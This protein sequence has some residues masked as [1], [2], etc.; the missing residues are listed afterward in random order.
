M[1]WITLDRLEK[2]WERAEIHAR[3]EGEVIRVT[4]TNIAAF[5]ITLSEKPRNVVINDEEVARDLDTSAAGFCKLGG[6][7][8]RNPPDF[9]RGLHKTHGLTG[10]I[11][12]AFM[13]SFILVRPTGEA[14]NERV[15]AWA[16]GELQR[17]VE[18]WRRVFR[19]DARVKNDSEITAEDIARHNLVL[20][21]D[22]GS[23]QLLAR[24]LPSLPL[25]W[26]RAQLR[27]G[28]V[29]ASPSDHA[30]IMIYPNPLN[31]RRYVVINSG[32]TYREYDY[33]NN[34]RQVPRLPDFAVIDVSK[35]V[36]SQYPGGVAAAG[37]FDEKWQLPAK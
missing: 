17:A 1:K 21:G 8:Q 12:D 19:G 10:P 25:E 37:F 9:G 13:D 11:D 7:W 32:F 23:N 2:H 16:A 3:I 20:W 29:S 6:K 24:I 26:T 27:L 22:P 35:P 36:T 28:A 18:E 5:T 33:L 34:A 15:R 30:P 4:A 31:P 14:F